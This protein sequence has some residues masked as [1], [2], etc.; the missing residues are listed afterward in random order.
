MTLAADDLS[1]RYG[2]KTV[3]DGVS[4]AFRTGE[5]TCVVGP[6]GAGKST[7]LSCLAGLRAPDAGV[8][9]LDG[10]P[11]ADLAPR[12]RARRIG[13]LPQAPEIAWSVEAATLVGLGRIPFIG[14]RGLGAEDHAAVAE[15]M[16]ATE[17]KDL[18][19]RRVDTLSGGERARVLIARVLAG[20]PRWILA[21]EPLA[22]L[23][24]G[25]VLDTASLL[26]AR[27]REDGC[28]VILTLHDLSVALRL[29]DRVIVLAEGGIITDGPPLQAL[30]PEAVS[31][32]YGVSARILEGAAGPM[33]EVTGRTC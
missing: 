12:E 20:R 2:K 15:A 16:A 23:D 5:V 27:A 9:R 18:A 7:L 10:A 25:H 31:R 4:C 22:G 14:A 6:N 30:S 24:P 3:L 1:V 32:A 13:F 19:G 8:T 17:V 26:R 28:G 33:L 29:A 21:D 11:L